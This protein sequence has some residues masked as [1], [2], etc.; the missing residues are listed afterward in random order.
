MAQLKGKGTGL[1]R[2]SSPTAPQLELPAQVRMPPGTPPNFLAVSTQ[3]LPDGMRRLRATEVLDVLRNARRKNLKFKQY[4]LS[5]EA[6]ADEVL[7]VAAKVTDLNIALYAF[8]VQNFELVTTYHPKEPGAEYV[9]V[10]F[11][12]NPFGFHFL[13]PNVTPV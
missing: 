1:P 8:R 9:G 4:R 13:V 3:V 10:L 12:D 11:S 6:S 2:L 5:K 7:Q